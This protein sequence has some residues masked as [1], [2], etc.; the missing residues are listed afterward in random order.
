MAEVLAAV[1]GLVTGLVLGL[2]GA[3]GSILAVP[4][5]MLGLGWSLTEAAPVALLAVSAAATLGT[6]VA[7]DVAYVRYRAALLMGAMGASF[8]P[9][10]LWL[11]ARLPETLLQTLFGLCM[12][13]VGLR[14]WRQTRQ[15]PEETRIVR[16]AVGGDAAPAGGP[17]CRLSHEGRF[18]WT[19]ACTARLAAIGGSAGLLSGLLGVGG[20]FVMVPALRTWTELSIHSAVATSL[21]TIALTSGGAAMSAGVTGPGLP[22]MQALPFTLGALAGMLTGRGLAPRIAGPRLQGGFA[23]LMLLLAAGFLVEALFA[24]REA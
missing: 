13:I 14:L 23:A 9:L 19:P 22:W 5:L 11:A 24:L 7:W 3:G 1:L 21:M 16:A 15:H 4:L 12:L 6:L 20:G 18:L 17:V 2:T 8:A 10:G